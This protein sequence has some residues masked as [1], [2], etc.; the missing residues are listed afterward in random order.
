MDKDGDDMEFH[1]NVILATMN[2]LDSEAYL[3]EM[4]KNECGLSGDR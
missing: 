3:G 2:S 1:D 4:P